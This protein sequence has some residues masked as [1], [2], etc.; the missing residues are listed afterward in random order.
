[1]NDHASYAP[2]FEQTTF[3]PVKQQSKSWRFS[4]KSMFF[5]MFSFAFLVMMVAIPP[6]GAIVLLLF[7]ICAAVALVIA[8]VYGRGWIRPFSIVAAI[9]LVVLPF[10]LVQ[11]HHVEEFFVITL[12]F[13]AGSVLVGLFGASIHG[14]LKRRMGVV[15]VPNIPIIR[16]MLSND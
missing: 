5:G 10:I 12:V 7:G 14:F 2:G 15:P 3:R 6:L 11:V 1:M 16:G 4:W 8:M 9:P 13:Y